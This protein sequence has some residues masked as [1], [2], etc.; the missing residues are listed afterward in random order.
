MSNKQ[1]KKEQRIAE[2]KEFVAERRAIQ[3]AVFEANFEAGLRI[4]ENAKDKLS[5]EEIEK[6][7]E[8]IKEN[9][10]LIE[11]LKSESNTGP[12]A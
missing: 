12:Q 7:E 6:I 10:A 8:Q 1:D 11:K 5:P 3:L 2:A 9:R 4:Y